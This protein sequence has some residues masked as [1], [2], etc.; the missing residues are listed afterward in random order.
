MYLLFHTESFEF[1]EKRVLTIV[2]IDWILELPKSNQNWHVV[3]P[4]NVRC[5]T[6]EFFC[7]SLPS[8]IIF[9]IGKFFYFRE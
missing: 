4:V 5:R 1:C 6:N 9:L 2:V 3:S 8:K 7:S